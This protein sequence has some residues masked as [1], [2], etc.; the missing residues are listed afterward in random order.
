M[1]ANKYV[2][3][4]KISAFF[5]PHDTP[6]AAHKLLFVLFR[7]RNDFLRFV[8]FSSTWIAVNILNKL[9]YLTQK[10]SDL[11]FEL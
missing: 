11:L 4:N 5:K 3:L 7:N 2:T 6:T 8:S 9:M 10:N 1:Y